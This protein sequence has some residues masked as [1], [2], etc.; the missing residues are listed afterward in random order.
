[1][2]K[3]EFIIILLFMQIMTLDAQEW[4]TSKDWVEIKDEDGYIL[5]L[6]YA[7]AHNFVD[8]VIYDCGR[9]FLRKD[10]A[11]QLAAASSEFAGKGFKIKLFD[12]YRPL[13]V[14]WELWEEVPDARYVADPRKGSMHNRGMAVD[15]TLVNVDTGEELDM[16]T[17]FD[18]FGPRAYHTNTPELSKTIQEN[19]KLLKVTL[20]KFGFKPIRTEWW[21]YSYTGDLGIW[22]IHKEKWECPEE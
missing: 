14:Q 13:E 5:D 17:D 8:H 18:F 3:L 1:M 15:L 22:P 21:H 2:I 20:E 12:C 10:V 9:C 16:G 11:Q 7:T 4:T 19:R 6:R